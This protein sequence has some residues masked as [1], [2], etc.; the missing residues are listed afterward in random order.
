MKWLR[1]IKYSSI[2]I[3]DILR[4]FSITSDNTVLWNIAYIYQTK[5]VIPNNWVLR[6]HLATLNSICVFIARKLNHIDNKYIQGH[7]MCYVEK[8]NR[9]C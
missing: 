7:F 4:V 3:S 5:C 2:K 8:S 1:V 9:M 6:K